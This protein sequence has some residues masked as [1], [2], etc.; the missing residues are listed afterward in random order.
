LLYGQ[1]TRFVRAICPA[2]EVVVSV[3]EEAERVLRTRAAALLD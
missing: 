3:S 2:D 1:S